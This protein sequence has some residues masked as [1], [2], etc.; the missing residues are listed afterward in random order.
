MG[1]GSDDPLKPTLHSAKASR[2]SKPSGVKAFF[3]RMTTVLSRFLLA[4]QQRRLRAW[5]FS[6]FFQDGQ[7]RGTAVLQKA[8][9]SHG[10]GPWAGHLYWALIQD[11]LAL[12]DLLNLP[13]ARDWEERGGAE[14][15]ARAETDGIPV[16]GEWPE[17]C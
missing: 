12:I 3:L 11:S 4:S 7:Q 6:A 1:Q 13:S 10:S 15:T 14:N 8:D 2:V 5:W 9:L 16:G 17:V